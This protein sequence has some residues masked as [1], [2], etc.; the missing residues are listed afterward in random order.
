MHQ[1]L[2]RPRGPILGN[3]IDSSSKL[4]LLINFDEKYELLINGF[5]TQPECVR[6]RFQDGARRSAL[7][8]ELD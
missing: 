2:L 6:A 4:G 5:L 3:D 7:S 1:L 8:S